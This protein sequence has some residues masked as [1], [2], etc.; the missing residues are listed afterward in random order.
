MDM[1]H[2]KRDRRPTFSPLSAEVATFEAERP[3]LQGLAYRMLGSVADAEDV[4][5]EAFLR[6]QRTDVAAV[7]D[8]RRFLTTTVA[9]LSLDALDTAK[10]RREVYV[11]PW[12][13]EPLAGP[14]P[15]PLADAQTISLA[16]LT[17]LER[18]SPL[19]RAA[20][21][22]HDVFDYGYAEVAEV[23]QRDEA[24]VRQLVHRARAHAETARLR[25]APNA[26]AHQRVLE[27]FLAAASAGDV[28]SLERLLAAD[29]VALTDGGGRVRGTARRP[30]RGANAV[31]RFFVGLTR[32][33]ATRVAGV[34]AALANGEPVAVVR[35]TD[36]S[37]TLIALET[38]GQR[39][40]A[41]RIVRNPDKLRTWAFGGNAVGFPEAAS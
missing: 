9:R 36:G 38:D 19:E 12:I 30:V 1:S 5:Q 23:L 14:A 10:R 16:L 26:A 21:L 15:G 33:M 25:Y 27:A 28:A 8:A 13:P 35:L 20:F 22:L 31:A 40:Y 6:W 7:R 37:V 24:A 2:Q 11:G 41:A 29:A 18:L 4:L 17:V 32:K 39:V 34:E 3:Y